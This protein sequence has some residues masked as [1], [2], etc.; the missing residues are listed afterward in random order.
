LPISKN[1][2]RNKD[3][4]KQIKKEFKI[5]E[6]KERRYGRKGCRYF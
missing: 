4:E 5:E 3:M 2:G 1:K 6:G